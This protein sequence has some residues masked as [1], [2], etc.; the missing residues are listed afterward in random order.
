[1]TTNPDL[2]ADLVRELVAL[3]DQIEPA[4]A[5]IADIKKVLRDLDFGSHKI[6]GMTV[7]VGHNVRLDTAAFEAAYPVLEHPQM[8]KPTPDPAAIRRHLSPVQLEALQTEGEK[9]LTVK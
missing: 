9:R 1:M 2:H 6:A 5:R 7:T 8:Y 4:N 3:Q